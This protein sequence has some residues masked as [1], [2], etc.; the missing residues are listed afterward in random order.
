[1][2]LLQ[3]QGVVRGEEGR[4]K[5]RKGIRS[6]RLDWR[7]CSRW[8]VGCV[9]FSAWHEGACACV[10]VWTSCCCPVPVTGLCFS[11]CPSIGL[12]VCLPL[13]HPSIP[14]DFSH[15]YPAFCRGEEHSRNLPAGAYEG[16]EKCNF[17]PPSS[18]GKTA[19]R[20]IGDAYCVRYFNQFK[21]SQKTSPARPP[22]PARVKRCPDAKPKANPKYN[23]P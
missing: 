17:L 7:N 20:Q 11:C 9:D 21:S 6:T 8:A 10:S 3:E 12:S 2:L 4:K 23:Q 1:M 5:G 18:R 15:L 22:S 16:P 19:L 13:V 14:V